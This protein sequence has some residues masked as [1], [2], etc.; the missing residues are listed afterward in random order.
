MPYLQ[1]AEQNFSF[2]MSQVK[3][4]WWLRA[5]FS[6]NGHLPEFVDEQDGKI[7]CLLGPFLQMEKP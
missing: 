6:W 1:K 4:A 2:D 3:R 7:K 5:W